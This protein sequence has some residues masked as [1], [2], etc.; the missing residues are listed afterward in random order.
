MA[1]ILVDEGLDHILT[2]WPKN[3]L[4]DA[5]LYLGLFASQTAST[6]PARTATGG[7]TPVGWTEVTGTGY[8]RIQ[9]TAANWGSPSTNG[10]GRKITSAAKVFTADGAWAAANGYFLAT[11]SA[12]EAG[13]VMIGFA[14][15]DSG[16][17]RTL[18]VSGDTL[19]VTPS[20]QLDG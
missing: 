12:S 10:S 11:H 1:E 8:A 16:V 2:V 19:T 5:S 4:N 9:I 3:G 7:V 20:L 13:D 15:F 14:N 18:Q 17:A 6:V